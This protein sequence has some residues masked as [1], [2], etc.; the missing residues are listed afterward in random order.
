[1]RTLGISLTQISPVVVAAYIVQLTQLRSAPTVKLQMAAIR[2]LFDFI[3]S[4]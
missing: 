1:M 4:L 2:T 3:V